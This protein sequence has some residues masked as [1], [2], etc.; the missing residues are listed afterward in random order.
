M[1]TLHSSIHFL[2]REESQLSHTLRSVRITQKCV[3]IKVDMVDWGC[4]QSSETQVIL[5]DNNGCILDS[6]A[7]FLYPSFV[8]YKSN[9]ACWKPEACHSFRRLRKYG[10]FTK[11]KPSTKVWILHIS[12][13]L[14]YLPGLRQQQRVLWSLTLTTRLHWALSPSP[15]MPLRLVLA[16]Q[17][18]PEVMFS[19]H[20]LSEEDEDEIYLVIKVI[21]S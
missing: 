21:K 10:F 4:L 19:T 9:S 16:S 5:S 8:L 7:S 3:M 13:M 14:V 11:W 2:S 6:D 18:A 15:L 20:S 1:E 12:C 17:D